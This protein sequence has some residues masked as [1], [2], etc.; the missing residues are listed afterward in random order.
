V[1]V[2][3]VVPTWNEAP[4]IEQALAALDSQQPDEVVVAD[5]GSVDGTP[6]IA[7]RRARVVTSARG[8]ARQIEAGVA[9]S[10]G[11]VV[12]VLHADCRLPMGALD[13]V[14]RVMST[15]EVAGGAFHKRFASTHLL[16]AGVRWRTRLWHALGYSF[17]DQAQFARRSALESI[18]GLRSDVVAED[19]DLA[20]RLRATGRVVLLDAEVLVSAR[21]LERDGVLRTWA[22][23]WRVALRQGAADR[24]R[25]WRLRSRR[26]A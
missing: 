11:D 4:A 22:A 9:A 21:R 5:G 7:S 25:A 12:L 18:G 17:G 24:V 15:P 1:R 14:R 13:A 10:T 19:M 6:D 8:R 3:V 16:L 2:S 26:R 23:W 20:W